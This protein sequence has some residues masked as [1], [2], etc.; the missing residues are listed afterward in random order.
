MKSKS[1][2]EF[3]LRRPNIT[4]NEDDANPSLIHPNKK[5][6][7]C[8]SVPTTLFDVESILKWKTVDESLH[9]T[10][11][12]ESSNNGER[13]GLR[14]KNVV[15]RE[16]ARTVGDNPSCSSGPPVSISWEYTE[17]GELGVE[18]YE[19]TR[20]ARRSHFE[21]VLPRKVRQDMLKREWNITQREIAESVRRNVKIKN[22]RKATVNNLKKATKMEE[23]M[24]SLSRK[25][26]RLVLLQKPVSAQVRDL[27][28]K[29]DE[30]QRMRSKLRLQ[31]QMAQEYEEASTE[32]N[33]SS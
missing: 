9:S 15:I 33:S 20:P 7:R 27:E 26:K 31:M 25:L 28:A 11:G 1:N 30:S 8:V 3:M 2:S 16:Y 29:L 5:Y 24:E 14:F 23:A 19:S 18:E 21:M 10:Y 12:S 17:I 6:R 22:Q 4:I 13:G 32:E